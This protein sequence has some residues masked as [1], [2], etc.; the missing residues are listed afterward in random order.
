[1]KKYAYEAPAAQVIAF[2]SVDVLTTSGGGS[3]TDPDIIT[4]GW[5][6]I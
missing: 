5:I 4:G 3:Y 2:N 6:E 1:M